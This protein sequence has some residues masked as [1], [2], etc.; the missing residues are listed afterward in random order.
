MIVV[1]WVRFR[2]RVFQIHTSLR[3][4]RLLAA[5]T[6]VIT[7]AR[8]QVRPIIPLYLYRHVAIHSRGIISV[9]FGSFPFK[10]LTKWFPYY[11]HLAE[12]WWYFHRDDPHSCCRYRS[13]EQLWSSRF[14]FICNANAYIDWKIFSG[15]PMG[16]APVAH[17]LFSRWDWVGNQ[18]LG[19]SVEIAGSC[20]FFNA[21]PKS[22]KWFNRDRFV[23]SNGWAFVDAIGAIKLTSSLPQTCVS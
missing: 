12:K 13:K 2:T 6:A 20:S 17:V 16:M 10:L 22:S 14:V 21:N 3:V 8:N 5:A 18:A 4:I 7:S 19:C 15:A 9:N 11:D 23:L 1:A